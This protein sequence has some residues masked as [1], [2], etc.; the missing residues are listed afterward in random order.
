MVSPSPPFQES[1]NKIDRG[2]DCIADATVFLFLHGYFA[3]KAYT[4]VDS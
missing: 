4:V 3:L 2:A 1:H